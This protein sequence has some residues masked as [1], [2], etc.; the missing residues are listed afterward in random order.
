MIITLKASI[1]AKSTGYKCKACGETQFTIIEEYKTAE[2][3]TLPVIICDSC[4]KVYKKP[5]N[6]RDENGLGY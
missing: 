5:T 2:G 1:V 3:N 6:F 4:G